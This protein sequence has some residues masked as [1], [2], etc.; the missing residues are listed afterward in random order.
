[1]T[2]KRTSLIQAGMGDDPAYKSVS[3]PIYLSSTYCF[4]TISE[5]GKYDYGRTANPNRNELA[6]ALTKLENGFSCVV[7]S[8]GMSAID[9]VTNLFKANALIV[10]PNDC[11]AGTHRLLSHRAKQGRLKVRFIDFLDANEVSEVFKEKPALL[12][13]ES[14]S[15][16]LLRLV[17]ISEI[18]EFAK[19]VGALVAVDNTLLS[20]VRQRPLDLG[21]DFSIHSTTKY[22]NGHSDVVGG[23]IISK[24]QEHGDQLTWW[25][26]CLGVTGSPFDSYMTL[27]GMRTL[28]PRMDSQESSAMKVAQ[29]LH[30]HPKITKVYYPGLPSDSGYRLCKKQQSGP[31]AMISFEVNGGFNEAKKVIESL[32]VFQLAPSLGGVESLISYPPTMTHG[33]ISETLRCTAGIKESLLRISI[34]LESSE[35]IIQDLSASFTL[36]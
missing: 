21:A 34:G 11:Y 22:L 1:M 26:N 29:F 24:K 5:K 15:N 3:P 25:A 17:D 27:R 23:A 20:P 2:S 31:G 6:E 7:T 28:H 13:L 14:P 18:C 35:D 9:L 30:K 19:S 16:P 32:K 36:I 33:G 4:D 8:S 12:L 10:A